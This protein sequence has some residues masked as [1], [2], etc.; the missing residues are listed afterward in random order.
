MSVHRHNFGG[1]A[2]G[3]LSRLE[4]W[5][6]NLVLNLRLWCEGAGGQSRVWS[7]YRRALP[8]PEAR[9][10]CETFEYLLSTVISVSHRPLV[11]HEAGC[12]CVGSDEA[13]F[14]NLVRT[15]SE[16]H[17]TDAALIATLMVGPA[18][19]EQIAML[20]GQVGD[21]LRRIHAHRPAMSAEPAPS[22]IPLH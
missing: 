13:V 11:R 2:V 4:A 9:V 22:G 14:V 8:G 1:A 5:E 12:S 10:E 15:A 6:A 17:L 20:A 16:G 7:E 19:A 18:Q 3:V 21:T